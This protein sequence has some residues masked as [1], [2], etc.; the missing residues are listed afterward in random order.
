MSVEAPV[1]IVG[2]EIDERMHSQFRA[3]N[4][5]ILADPSILEEIPN[6]SALFLIPDD[7]DEEFLEANISLGLDALRKGRSVFFKRLAPGEWGITSSRNSSEP[8]ESQEPT[9]S[10]DGAPSR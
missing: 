1:A 6:E 9:V 8:A 5:A 7:A 2:A 4:R 10:A 3:L